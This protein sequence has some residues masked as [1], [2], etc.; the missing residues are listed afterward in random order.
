MS[1]AWSKARERAEQV[2]KSG[3]LFI[4]LQNSGD[5]VVGAFCGDPMAREI[6]KVGT[7]MEP[8]D[9]TNPLH[10]GLKKSVRFALNFWVAAEK[11]MKIMEGSATWFTDVDKVCMKYGQDSWLFE[12]ERHGVGLDTTYS[13]LPETTLTTDQKLAIKACKLHDLVVSVKKDSGGAEAP[14][15][16]HDDAPF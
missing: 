6:V 14:F 5:K 12:V 1:D 8:Y 13:I 2:Q 11:S 10:E 4:R 3:G 16:S 9:K 7:K 15:G